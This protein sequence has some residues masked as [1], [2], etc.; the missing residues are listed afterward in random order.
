MSFAHLHLH[1]EYSLLDGAC[2]IDGLMDRVKELGQTAVAITDHGVMY[3]CI[4]FYKAAKAAGVKPIIGCE[5]YVTRRGMADRI[6]GIDNDPYHLVLLCENRKGYENLCLL[7]SEAF[8]HGFYGKPRIDLALLEQHHEGLIAL[9]A[10]LAG[11]I[12]QYLMDEDYDSAKAYALRLSEIFGPGNFYLE[13]QDHGIEEQRPVNQGVM[14]IARET[15]LPLVVTNDAHYLRKEDAQ[16][17]DVLL[18]IQTGKTVDE[19]NRMRFSTDEFY[20]KSEQELRALFPGC[21]E[22][23]ENT[24]KIAE[25]C[26][27][28]FTFHEY[29]L[30][31]FPVPEGYTN[32]A[33]F[34][35]IC[36]DGF[37]ERYENPPQEYI[38]R[39]E[40]E[41]SVI[42]K[43][44]YVNYYLIVW[45]FIRYAK[46]QGIPVGPGRGSGAASIAAYCMHI[47]EVDPM[48]YA[49]IFERFLN[50]ERV[51]MPDFDTDFCQERRPEVIDYVMR[52]YGSDHVAQ[53]ATFG[54]MAA[55][56]AI[57]DVGRA[58]N[59]TYAQTDIVAKLVPATPHITLQEALEVSPKLKQM[60]DEDDQVKKLIDTAR[61]L[62]GMPRNTSTHA[63]GVVITADPVS[64]YLPLSKN[65]DTVVT[66]YTMTTIEELGL[67]KMDFLGLRNLTVIEDAQR[68]IQKLDPAFDIA[69][70][71]D[72]DAETFAMLAEGKTQGVFQLESA[73]ITGVCVNMKP[74]SI[75]DLTAIVALYRPGPMDSIP[76]FIANKLDHR[77]ITYKTPLLEPI[78]KVTYGCIVYQ[79]QVIEIFRSLGGYTMGQ[80]DNIRRAISK[81]KMKVIAEERK[82]FVYGDPAQNISGCVGHGVPERVAQSI[83]DEIVDFA[84]YAFNKAHAVCYAVVSYQ[85]A[86]L[87]CHYPRQY[88][89]ALM[90][91]VLDSATKISGYISECK[92]MGIQVL[93]PDL[94][95]SE[96]LFTVEA[97]A[98]R[99]GLGAVKNVGRGL[100]RTM[101]RKREEGGPFKSLEDFLERMGEGELNKRAVENFIKCG[102]A[103]CF[104][105]NRS[106]LL[107]V[108]ENMMDSVSA[109]RKKNLEG[110]MGL[111]SMLEEEDNG[112]KIP[113]PKLKELPKAELL[114][115]EKETT[116]IYLSGHPMDDYRPF[117]RNTHVIPM[118]KLLDE[119]SRL[120]DD[121][122]VSVAGV[123]QSVKMKTTR[124][125]SM[126]AYVTVE[127][128]TAAIEMLAFSNIISQHGGYLREGSAVVITG[129]LSLRD[130]KEPQIV[131]NRA[132]PISDYAEQI[133]D[134][135]CQ[136]AQK[137]ETLYLRLPSEE[138]KLYPR[139]RAIVNMFPGDS[140]VV[141]YFSDTR[142]RRGTRAVL[143]ENMLEELRNVLGN[144]NVVLK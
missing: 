126:M 24:G 133:P 31:S 14:R 118:S 74:T 79:E 102:A 112:A 113:I 104:G 62:E 129:R 57:R 47:T 77:K 99:F 135:P 61:S 37:R 50:P 66:Q 72:D 56:G 90:T 96:D 110:Q 124:N 33:Y 25:R 15:G 69:K 128:D 18:C 98:I 9:S 34:R 80:A 137:T 40:Y 131:I 49:L 83:Y 73:G 107:A 67:L 105:A 109:S 8:L 103:D 39:L 108:Y 143:M 21:D 134:V 45:D 27:L 64:T 82:T 54:T 12:P 92:D 114:A 84:N 13:M 3:G 127:D 32:E 36:T 53:I 48:K 43:M 122:I 117:L 22:A 75:E 44:G 121:Q 95:H 41:I 138:G 59:F 116:G 106:E 60:Y 58:L 141:L 132:R 28:E 115:M 123:V 4:D 16:M 78:L 81:K 71:P 130:D 38:D 1:T 88:M 51:S 55:R 29:H 11:A 94:N 35:K 125:N 76:T 65:D 10:C 6:H 87:K 111:F 93:P 70:V 136:S 26:N 139:I 91:S 85:T 101:V 17:Q 144:E 100:I 7:V 120:E 68:Q 20:L 142:K 52:K 89:A 63:A 42:S 23:F 19:P 86:Y 30:P 46:E 5:V 97:E 2:R 119:E 140:P